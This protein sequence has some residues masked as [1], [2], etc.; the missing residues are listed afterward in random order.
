MENWPTTSRNATLRGAL[1]TALG[2]QKVFPSLLVH[3]IGS[4]E[5][6][7]QLPELLDRARATCRATWSGAPWP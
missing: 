5:K 6:T 7:G 1:S 2:A 3:L 4:G